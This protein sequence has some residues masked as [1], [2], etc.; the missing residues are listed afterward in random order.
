MRVRQSTKTGPFEHFLSTDRGCIPC[1]GVYPGKSGS[2]GSK[3]LWWLVSAYFITLLHDYIITVSYH[4]CFSFLRDFILNIFKV[5]IV[6]MVYTEVKDAHNHRKRYEKH[7][8]LSTTTPHHKKARKRY[9]QSI[10]EVYTV[11][12]LETRVLQTRVLERLSCRAGVCRLHWYS[13]HGHFEN[14]GR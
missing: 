14:V 7:R 6:Y 13:L 3:V 5:Y 10:H 1:R 11:T 9:A 4:Y 8:V 2:P 12:V